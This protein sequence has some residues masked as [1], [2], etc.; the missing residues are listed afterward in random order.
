MDEQRRLNLEPQNQAG[1]SGMPLGHPIAAS[2][3]KRILLVED[4]E[5]ALSMLAHIV[6]SFGYETI[7]PRPAPMG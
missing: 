5:A 3:A 2:T 6:R 7:K 4:Y 1:Y